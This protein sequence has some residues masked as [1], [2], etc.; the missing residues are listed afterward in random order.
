MEGNR[1]F[2]LFNDKSDTAGFVKT[3]PFVYT[4]LINTFDLSMSTHG[5]RYQETHGTNR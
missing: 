1:I 3:V 5:N 4:L 2:V